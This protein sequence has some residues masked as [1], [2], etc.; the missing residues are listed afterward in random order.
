MKPNLKPLIPE[1]NATLLELKYDRDTESAFSLNPEQGILLPHA[2][3]EFILTYTPQEVELIV[4][5]YLQTPAVYFHASHKILTVQLSELNLI[6][7]DYALINSA[8]SVE[9]Y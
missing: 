1:K 7:W 2:D 3:H 6:R 4:P 9:S 5:S 8:R